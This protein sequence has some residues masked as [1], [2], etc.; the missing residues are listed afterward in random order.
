MVPGLTGAEFNVQNSMVVFTGCYK[1]EIPFLVKC[2][3]E[4]QNCQFKLKFGTNAKS[5]MQ[6]SMVMFTSTVFYQKYPFWVDLVQKIQLASL[7]WNLAAGL[8]QICRIQWDV[9]M[10]V[11]K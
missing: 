3:P 4:N 11:G 5:N 10:H 1:S 9:R 7:S 8:I 2:G 6:N